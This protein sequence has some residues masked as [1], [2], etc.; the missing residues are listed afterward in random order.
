MK[1]ETQLF[2][3]LGIVI[4]A[5]LLA[6]LGVQFCDTFMSSD[7]PFKSGDEVMFMFS[8]ESKWGAWVKVVKV[9]NNFF[10]VDTALGTQ[11]WVNIHDI[12]MYRIR[13]DY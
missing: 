6:I 4:S 5:L 11:H 1:K 9:R 8:S 13:G 10:Y 2:L 3:G 12:S 7:V